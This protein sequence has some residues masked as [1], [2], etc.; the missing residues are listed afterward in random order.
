MSDWFGVSD[1]TP[2]TKRG[3]G[4][5]GTLAAVPGSVQPT[6]GYGAHLSD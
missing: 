3:M 5:K 4:S 1:G 6:A 2:Q